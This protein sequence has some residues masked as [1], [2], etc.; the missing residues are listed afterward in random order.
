[1]RGVCAP[2]F[3]PGGVRQVLKGAA[4]LAVG[5]SSASCKV[6]VWSDADVTGRRTV[7]RAHALE[8]A[9]QAARRAAHLRAQ[10]EHLVAEAVARAEEQQ[11]LLLE[12]LGRLAAPHGHQ[13]F[14]E[15]P[16]LSWHD[17]DG[18]KLTL[19]DSITSTLELVSV[20]RALRAYRRATRS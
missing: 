3:V 16:L 17:I 1:M 15:V 4:P 11:A 14:L 19:A 12:L 20:R 8:G 18:S 10:V 7:H 13:G 2:S 9:L 5:V 6:V